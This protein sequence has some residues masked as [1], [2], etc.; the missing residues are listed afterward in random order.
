MIYSKYFHLVAT[1]LMFFT[2]K[3]LYRQRGQQELVRKNGKGMYPSGSGR[4]KAVGWFATGSGDIHPD[5]H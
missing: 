1:F 2:E 3:C 4:R 5:R